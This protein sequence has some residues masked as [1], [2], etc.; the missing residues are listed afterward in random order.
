[1]EIS[2]SKSTKNGKEIYDFSEYALL[3]KISGFSKASPEFLRSLHT[4]LGLKM[5]MKELA[6]LKKHYTSSNPPSILELK[7]LDSY[8][9]GSVGYFDRAISQIEIA[10]SNPHVK[11]A[12]ELYNKIYT[13]LG[14][15]APRT[16]K[17]I[18]SISTKYLV[19]HD[20]RTIEFFGDKPTMGA[21]CFEK[22]S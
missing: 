11:K 2:Q 3:R 21:D 1:M 4:Q 17:N 12:L 7:A 15:T 22:K 14:E 20:L 16:L 5:S 8:W 18:S 9:S 13:E 19:N 10:T 6:E